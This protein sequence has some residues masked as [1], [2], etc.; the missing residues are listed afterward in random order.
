MTASRPVLAAGMV[1]I[2][3]REA[4]ITEREDNF[5]AFMRSVNKLGGGIVFEAMSN[6]EIDRF[7]KMCAARAGLISRAGASSDVPV[8]PHVA[9]VDRSDEQRPAG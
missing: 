6:P 3:Q 1:R 5:R 9:A 7:M 8:A 4:S 2:M